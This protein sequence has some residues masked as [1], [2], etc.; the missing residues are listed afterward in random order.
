M[1]FKIEKTID[2]KI[3]NETLLLIGNKKDYGK[4]GIDVFL[5]DGKFTHKGNKIS[6]VIFCTLDFSSLL[7]LRVAEIYLMQLL[8]HCD[9]EILKKEKA[10]Y[11]KKLTCDVLIRFKS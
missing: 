5:S 4:E 6:A 2:F 7:K 11:L 1:N 10:S 3:I 8:T 9:M